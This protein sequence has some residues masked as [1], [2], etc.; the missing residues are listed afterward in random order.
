V[1]VNV[2]NIFFERQE[3]KSREYD[4]QFVDGAT[5]ADLD[6]SLVQSIADNYL[7]GISVEKYLQQ[8]GLTEYS[9][10]GLRVRMSAILLFAKDIQKRH[11]RSQVRI[12]K[13]SG[14]KLE[15]GEKY[16]FL[17]DEFVTGNIF[18][19]LVKSWE[20]LR[21]FLAF[22]TEFGQAALFQQKYIYPE[23]ACREALVNAIAHRDYTIQNC[24]DVYVFDDRME[25]K[26]PGTPLST[27]SI[28]DLWRLKN[29]HESRN[30]LI[31][32]ILR[33]NKFMREL[34]EGMKRIFE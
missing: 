33:E 16:N 24:I 5:T 28:E 34:G 14:T 18:E 15:A 27:I 3:Q 32:R 22:K 30:A 6:V 29:V 26:S 10:S 25:I 9:G 7:R 13:V 2:N 17:S 31:S 12:L 4:R 19:L 23:L 1:P 21:S 11:P 20:A 8:I